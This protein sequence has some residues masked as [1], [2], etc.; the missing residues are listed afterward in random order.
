MLQ[1]L[2]N[3]SFPKRLWQ[4]QAG[5]CPGCG[6]LIDD[7]DQ[8]L[9]KPVVPIKVGGVRSLANLKMLHSTCQRRFRIVNGKLSASNTGVPAP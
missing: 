1:L 3:R 6:Q 7:E 5:Q 9:I 2:Q 4:Q 8:W